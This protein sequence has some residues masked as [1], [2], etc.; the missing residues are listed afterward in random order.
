M[1]KLSFVCGPVRGLV[2]PW[3]FLSLFCIVDRLQN[4]QFCTIK[5][6]VQC[7]PSGYRQLLCLC[8]GVHIMLVKYPKIWEKWK[9]MPFINE[10]PHTHTS[11]HS[12][13][14]SFLVKTR[15]FVAILWYGITGSRREKNGFSCQQVHLKWKPKLNH[16]YLWVKCS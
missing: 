16:L 8:L 9:D 12:L 15:T 7:Y 2:W 3:L 1:W 5:L 10:H 13:S 4:S 11:I 6:L 14:K